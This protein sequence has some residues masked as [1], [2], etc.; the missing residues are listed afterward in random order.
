M[1][2]QSRRREN[3][4]HLTGGAFRLRDP[5]KRLI[6]SGRLQ[7]A[8]VVG[9]ATWRFDE[10]R[11]WT[12][13]IVYDASVAQDAASLHHFTDV[14]GGNRYRRLFSKAYGHQ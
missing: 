3:H 2:R 11:N 9:S 14:N 7:P 12:G 4:A 1:N 6:A 5:R 8:V 13:P 10:H